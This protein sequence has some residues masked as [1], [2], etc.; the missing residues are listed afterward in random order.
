MKNK[1]IFLF[2]CVAFICWL[3]P[4]LLGFF[5]IDN[6]LVT[7]GAGKIKDP[8]L[9]TVELMRIGNKEGAYISIIFIS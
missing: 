7:N 3:L 2:F 1:K 8:M 4:F 9:N 5:L 6:P